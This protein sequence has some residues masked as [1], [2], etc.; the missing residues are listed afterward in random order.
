MPENK[1][2]MNPEFLS[3]AS[4]S[5]GP[6]STWE[7]SK[8]ISE[9]TISNTTNMVIAWVSGFE[10]MLNLLLLYYVMDCPIFILGKFNV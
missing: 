6:R 7:G 9:P 1:N 5:A 8:I 4:T 3:A 2:D 10:F